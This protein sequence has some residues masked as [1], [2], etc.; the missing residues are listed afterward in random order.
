M[1]KLVTQHDCLVMFVLFLYISMKLSCG[2]RLAHVQVLESASCK[3]KQIWLSDSF[4]YL[5]HLG[6]LCWKSPKHVVIGMN[7]V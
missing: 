4:F 5:P 6:I 2:Q 7:E 1:S 3:P